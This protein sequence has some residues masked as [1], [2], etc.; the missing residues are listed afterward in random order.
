MRAPPRRRLVRAVQRIGAAAGRAR[1][2]RGQRQRADGAAAAGRRRETSDLGVARRDRRARRAEVGGERR[3][4]RA[5][6]VELALQRGQARVRRALRLERRRGRHRRDAHCRRRGSR[7]RGRGRRRRR[8]RRLR[9]ALRV[10]GALA[11][12][13]AAALGELQELRRAALERA[14]L[15][16][17]RV[18]AAAAGERCG[19]KKKEGKEVKGGSLEECALAAVTVWKTQGGRVE[20]QSS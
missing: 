3:E 19:G 15:A 1:R 18:V 6:G 2:R 14:V 13:R 10:V 5:F 12:G 20:G 7:G 4:A 8:R 9:E 17:E 11:P 16:L